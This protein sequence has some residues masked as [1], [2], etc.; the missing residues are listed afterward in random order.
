[1]MQFHLPKLGV[2]SLAL[3][4]SATF[5]PSA[6]ASVIGHLSVA[7][8]A[9]GGVSVSL[10]SISWLPGAPGTN[11]CLQVS[12]N[13]NVTS[14]GDGTLT[15][16]FTGTG[17]INDIPPNTGI[18]GFMS[19]VGT[20]VNMHFDLSAIGG[21][22]PGAGTPCTAG[23]AVGQSC[24]LSG[25]PFILTVTNNGTAVEL[26]ARGT[27]A[28]TVGPP[29]NWSG[30]FT[31]QIAGQTPLQIQNTE[32]TGGTIT[33]SYSGEFNISAVPEPVSMTLMGAG[34][35]ALAVIRRRKQ[36]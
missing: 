27:I 31:T 10:T 4:A 7:N 12:V 1:M 20:G 33:S 5:L 28:D 2:L 25:S 21:F 6:S 13:T 34:L 32:L 19:F 24:S 22:G 36:A 18:L 9:N 11:A 17:T 14:T 35:I 3:L 16:A 23:M 8:C 26:D 15:G 30:A 29:S